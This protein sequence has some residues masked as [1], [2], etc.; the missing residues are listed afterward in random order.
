MNVAAPT[1]PPTSTRVPPTRAQTR[2]ELK[3]GAFLNAAAMLAS[4]FRA[5]FTLLI[6]R[7][8]GPIALGIFSVAWATTDLVSKIGIIGLDDAVMTFVARAEAVGDRR[9]SRIYFR[10]ANLIAFIQSAIVA[11]LLSLG[12]GRAGSF[13]GLDP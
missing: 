12:L 2:R 11:A 6:A 4:N 1:A 3:R 8:L 7:L 9:R 10:A 13:F 5:I